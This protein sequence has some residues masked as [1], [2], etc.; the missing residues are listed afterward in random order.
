MKKCIALYQMNEKESGTVTHINAGNDFSRRLFDLGLI[1]G[2]HIACVNKGLFGSPIAYEICGS[3]I[4]L[5]KN[6][7][8]KIGV[9]L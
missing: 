3:K 7:A 6:D 9:V 8:K 4:A 2:Q 1:S 5:R